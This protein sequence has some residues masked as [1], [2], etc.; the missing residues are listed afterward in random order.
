MQFVIDDT[1]ANRITLVEAANSLLF[2]RNA[3]EISD[4]SWRDRF[5]SY[6]ATL[7]S[8]GTATAKQRREMGHSYEVL[9]ASTLEELERLIVN[10]NVGTVEDD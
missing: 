3:I 9:V 4:R 2:L 7:E 1:R 8:A 10:S 6:V 5:T